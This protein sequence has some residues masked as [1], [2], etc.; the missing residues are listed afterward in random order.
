[1]RNLG[2]LGCQDYDK[3]Q[4]VSARYLHTISESLINQPGLRPMTSTVYCMD[5]I[6]QSDRDELDQRVGDL[7]NHFSHQG[8][9]FLVR[10]RK[11][12]FSGR[13]TAMI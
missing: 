1:M 9:V 13:R 3:S 2:F 4:A 6:A 10:R 12:S 8:F 11:R 7:A 5:G